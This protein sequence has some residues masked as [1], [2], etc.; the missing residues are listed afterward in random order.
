MNSYIW[1]WHGNEILNF[2]TCAMYLVQLWIQVAV[3]NRVLTALVGYLL[4]TIVWILLW[5]IFSRSLR[6][7]GSMS[8]F[9]ASSASHIISVTMLDYFPLGLKILS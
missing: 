1:A 4:Q 9:A 6:G 5:K 3:L 2:V 8:K 7:R